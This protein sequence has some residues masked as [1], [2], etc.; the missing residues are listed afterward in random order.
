M[1]RSLTQ[2]SPPGLTPSVMSYSYTLFLGDPKLFWGAVRL[3]ELFFRAP[4]RKV[5]A[6]PLPLDAFYSPERERWGSEKGTGGRQK[7]GDQFT[8]STFRPQTKYTCIIT[9]RKRKLV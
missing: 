7:L 9:K 1:E 5:E 6:S 3:L 4:E 2:A 8:F